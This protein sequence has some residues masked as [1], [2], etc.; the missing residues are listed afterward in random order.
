MKH[1]KAK[2]VEVSVKDEGKKTVIRVIDD[3]VGF[4][5]VGDP[6]D[7]TS[8][9]AIYNY[10]QD[11]YYDRDTYYVRLT[12]GYDVPVIKTVNITMELPKVGTTVTAEKDEDG[13][14]IWDTQKPQA[15]ITIPTDSHYKLDEYN[16]SGTTWNYMYWIEDLDDYQPFVGT[17]ERGKTYYAEIW[18][19][20]EEG[21]VFSEDLKIYVNG[22]EAEEVEFDEEELGFLV[23]VTPQVE[24]EVLEGANQTVNIAKGE[25]LSFRVDIEYADFLA[26][27]KVY[28]D[29][30]LVEPAN[31]TSK[32]ES[33]IITFTQ[34]FTKN[35]SNGNHTLRVV[36][37]DG[38]A[39]TNFTITSSANPGTG[40][41]TIIY[42][43]TLIVSAIGLIGIY[44]KVKDR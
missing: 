19:V 25:K 39:T 21:Y 10:R 41:N 43:I 36:V 12:Y 34:D 32:E 42:I 22:K 38:E 24:Y 13:D 6:D 37:D 9:T 40:D 3:G 5:T 2:N 35:L 7:I 14:Y 18:L 44:K 30:E 8:G 26:S 4:I 17:F 29:D 15:K 27:G 31:Y 28:V 33:T 11:D 16:E 1:S 23:E 20:P